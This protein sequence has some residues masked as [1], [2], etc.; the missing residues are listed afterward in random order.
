MIK[1]NDVK[2][3][4]LSQF[5]GMKGKERYNSITNDPSI[6][7]ARG[8]EEK[9]SDFQ[10]S[11]WANHVR[12][13]SACS[14]WESCPSM[15]CP[16]DPEIGSRM[17]YDPE[18][19]GEF[20]DSRC[21]MA[22]AT[23]HRYWESLPEDLRNALPDLSETVTDFP[24]WALPK[25]SIVSRPVSYRFGFSS[26]MLFVFLSFLFLTSVLSIVIPSVPPLSCP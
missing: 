22:K 11:E 4:S 19:D 5:S 25:L 24:I 9:N 20:K 12:S 7:T 26:F 3:S 6:L 21:T 10:V 23:R 1:R 18:L 16:L 8:K 17:P 13:M 15:K 2:Q 14:R